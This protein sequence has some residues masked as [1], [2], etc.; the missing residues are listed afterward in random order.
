MK[1][2][3]LL[4]S[5]LMAAMAVPAVV[6][7]SYPCFFTFVKDSCW[8][9]YDVNVSVV[10]A[11]NNKHVVTVSI[12][13]GKSWARKK[14]RCN[15]GES[16]DYAATFSPVFWQSDEGRQFRGKRTWTL[17]QHMSKGD[18]A[19]DITVCYPEQFAEVPLP[20]TAGANCKCDFQSIP[21]VKPP[22]KR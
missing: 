8:T 19:W 4:S 1:H 15:G 20:P 11:S 12:P 2:K 21:P 22:K 10:D 17:P 13:K 5:M 6:S 16:F 14:T 18:T 3:F 7:A 9:D